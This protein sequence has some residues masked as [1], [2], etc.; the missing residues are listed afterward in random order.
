VKRLSLVL[1]A[2]ALAACALALAACG[3]SGDSGPKTFQ[4]DGFAFTFEYPNSWVPSDKATVADQLGASAD[5][6]IGIGLDDDDG[7]ILQ[8]Y[9]LNTEITASNLDLAKKELDGLMSQVDPSATGQTGD[10]AGFPSITYDAVAIPTP[11]DGESRLVALF[12]GDQEYLINCQSTPDHRDEV[13]AACD[14]ALSTLKG[15]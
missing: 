2:L 3:G 8:S 5:K 10:T 14:Q 6:T 7:I 4:E 13:N 9:T 1:S 12:Q 11:T 15:I